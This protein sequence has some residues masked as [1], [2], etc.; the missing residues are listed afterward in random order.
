MAVE[1]NG[2]TDSWEGFLLLHQLLLLLQDLAVADMYL[3]YDL[4]LCH[5]K[6]FP[7]QLQWY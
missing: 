1:V 5:V 3:Q 4:L 6:V 7:K 2:E